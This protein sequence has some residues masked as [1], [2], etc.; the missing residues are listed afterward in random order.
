MRRTTVSQNDDE[1]EGLTEKLEKSRYC[2]DWTPNPATQ[3][4]TGKFSLVTE[5]GQLYEGNSLLEVLR[6]AAA[7]Q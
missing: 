6:K 1:Y 3:G 2:I 5:Q 4:I 7:D